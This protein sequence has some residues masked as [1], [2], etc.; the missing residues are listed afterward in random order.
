MLELQSSSNVVFL[1]RS[2]KIGTVKPLGLI[3]RRKR[4]KP[5]GEIEIR[6]S[7]VNR[8]SRF[9]PLG[10][11]LRIRELESQICTPM[12]QKNNRIPPPSV[13]IKKLHRVQF[14]RPWP[15]LEY[16]YEGLYYII[17]RL[18]RGFVRRPAKLRGVIS[19]I[20]HIGRIGRI[21]I[22]RSRVDRNGAFKWFCCLTFIVH[23]LG[24]QA[25]SAIFWVRG[26]R[27]DE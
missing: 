1:I 20:G 6:T 25:R 15:K 19:P 14:G 4:V 3:E 8:R 2:S 26:V 21:P 12:S 17:M 7:F 16:L 27:G 11:Y 24:C 22:R 13:R 10:T 23:V 5:N 18:Q 9:A